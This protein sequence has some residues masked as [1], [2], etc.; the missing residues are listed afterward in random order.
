MKTPKTIFALALST[1]L[2]VACNDKAANAETTEVDTT[3]TT[4][5][6]HHEILAENLQTASFTIEGMECEMGCAKTIEKKLAGMDGIQSASVDF[7]TKEARVEY[8]ATVHTPQVIAKTVEEMADGETYKVVGLTSSSDQSS[9]YQE[10]EKPKKDKKS[11]KSKKATNAD[12]S[13]DKPAEKKAGC[14]SEG[15][16]SSCASKTKTASM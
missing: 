6:A 2:F 3:G 13:T 7:D 1:M 8:D 9:V 5:E 15:A 12:A 4:E 10:Q 16:K 11:K 14:C